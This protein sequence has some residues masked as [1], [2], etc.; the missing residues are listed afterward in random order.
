MIILEI[1]ILRLKIHKI[2]LGYSIEGYTVLLDEEGNGFYS[3]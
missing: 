1:E 3:N 2:D